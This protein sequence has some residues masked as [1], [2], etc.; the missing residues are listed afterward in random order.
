[1][2]DG[3]SIISQPTLPARARLVPDFPDYCATAEGLLYSSF[4]RSNSRSLKKWRRIVGRPDERG[5]LHVNLYRPDRTIKH[6]RV[7]IVIML[8]F[9]GPCP[10]GL[11]IRHLDGN[12]SHNAT[13]N[14]CYGTPKQNGEDSVRLGTISH[15]QKHYRALATENLVREVRRLRWLGLSFSAIAERV[16]LQKAHV[17][18]ICRRESWKHVD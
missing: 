4:V 1:M 15:G 3:H 14:L 10:A 9:V 2:A 16:N 17:G 8:T 6:V 7:H 5:Y 18:K 11:E 13:S 12:K